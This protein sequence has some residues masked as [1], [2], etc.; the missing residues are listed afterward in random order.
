MGATKQLCDGMTDP[1]KWPIC[2]RLITL[3]FHPVNGLLYVAD[4]YY[5]LLVVGPLGGLATQLARG[6]KFANGLDVDLLTGNVYF[7]DA[8]FT[9]E[10]RYY[11]QLGFKPDS[12]GRLLRY[13]PLTRQVSVLLCLVVSMVL[14]DLPSTTMDNLFLYLSR[15]GRG[16]QNTG[17][18]GRKQRAGRNGEFWVAVSNGLFPRMPLITPQGVWF[19]SNGVVLQSVSFGKELDG[20]PPRCGGRMRQMFQQN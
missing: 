18:W 10:I 11:V 16:F 3:S 1:N 6:F 19:N 14:V 12:T 17:L 20:E 2:R 4:V 8:S 13:N 7:S 15:L 5:G 9:Y